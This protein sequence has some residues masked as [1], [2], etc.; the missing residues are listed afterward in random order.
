MVLLKV[1]HVLNL[2]IR[3]H[4]IDSS[5]LEFTVPEFITVIVL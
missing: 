1:H 4:S 2:K 3:A 5:I